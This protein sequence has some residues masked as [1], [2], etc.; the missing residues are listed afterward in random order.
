MRAEAAGRRGGQ[1]VPS[2]ELAQLAARLCAALDATTN[3]RVAQY[4][5]TRAD[6]D[7]LAALRGADGLRLKPTELAARCRLSSGGTSNVLRRMSE[8]GYVVREA[9]LADGRSAWAQL[10]EEGLLITARIQDAV[11]A[12]QERRLALLPPGAVD[13]LSAL[14]AQ[15]AD[16]LEAPE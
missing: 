12:V 1:Q 13:A 9:D 8:S 7:V 14:L 5:L 10:T 6:Y 16:V 2:M 3:S 11:A 15:A 4:G